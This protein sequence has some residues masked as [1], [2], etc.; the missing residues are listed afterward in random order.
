MKIE[1]KPIGFFYTD[2]KKIPRHWT[3]SEAEGIICLE[4]EFTKAAR[5]IKVGQSI[6]VI[7]L[8]DRSR[9]YTSDDLLQTPKHKNEKKGVFSICSPVRPNPIGLSVLN[10]LAIKGN[11]ITV[12][13]ID[14]FNGTPIIDIKPHV[15]NKYD[16]PSGCEEKEAK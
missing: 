1:I 11:R 9:K 2:E 15:K 7:F 14:M 12:K 13:G 10:I 8:F 3:V 5:D 4:R 16:C 6:I